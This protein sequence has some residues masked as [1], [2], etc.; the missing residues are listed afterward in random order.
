M[1]WAQPR[2]VAIFSGRIPSLLFSIHH[3]SDL[4][5]LFPKVNF[6]ITLLHYY[7]LIN[8]ERLL[9][10]SMDTLCNSANTILGN[11]MLT[12]MRQCIVLCQLE[13]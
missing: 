6:T 1:V 8:L 7:C 11:N 5:I 2:F 4:H 12:S 9:S 13:S 10:P 3:S